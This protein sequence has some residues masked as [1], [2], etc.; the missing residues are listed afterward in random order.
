M[1]E[2][3]HTGITVSDLERSVEFYCS[4]FGLT[5]SRCVE[6]GGEDFEKAVGV[7]G[8][9]VELVMLNAGNTVVELLQYKT[10]SGEPFALRNNDVGSAH[11]CFTVTGIDDV[12]N[13]LVAKGVTGMAPPSVAPEDGPAVGTR[14]AYLL[15]PD[16]ITIELLEV[17]PTVSLAALGV[18]APAQA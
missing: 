17:G 16:G 6:M 12:Y 4:A 9:T 10:S 3:H 2:I 7:P 5:E 8:A 15:D 14:F 1:P 18:G 11:L 13:G